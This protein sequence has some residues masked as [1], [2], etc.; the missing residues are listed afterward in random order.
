M[1]AISS[2]KTSL[3]VGGRENEVL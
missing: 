2:T 1:M 3:R